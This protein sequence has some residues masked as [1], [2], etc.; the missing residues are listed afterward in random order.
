[1]E[2]GGKMK[3]GKIF[4]IILIIIVCSGCIH[5]EDKRIKNLKT[6]MQ[7]E[8]DSKE[9]IKLVNAIFVEKVNIDQFDYRE[10]GNYILIKNT[11]DHDGKEIHISIR[12][13]STRLNISII[14]G[15]FR[16]PTPPLDKI[17]VKGLL[18]EEIENQVDLTPAKDYSTTRRYYIEVLDYKGILSVSR[19]QV[20]VYFGNL[21]GPD[22]TPTYPDPIPNTPY[23]IFSGIVSGIIGIIIILLVFL[24]KRRE[25]NE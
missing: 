20:S 16:K 4:F 17:Y 8:L 7:P 10:S 1:M 13:Y 21:G 2:K 12:K 15:H 11:Y 23:Y 5:Q 22:P 3:K 9:F 19:A 24:K 6:E 18:T 25:K 14:Q